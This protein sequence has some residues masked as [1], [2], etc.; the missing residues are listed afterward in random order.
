MRLI[1][2]FDMN[3]NEGAIQGAKIAR[4]I[5]IKSMIPPATAAL[6]ASSLLQASDQRTSLAHAS[7]RARGFMSRTA[8][9]DKRL[10]KIIRVEKKIVVPRIIV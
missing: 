6:L 5:K 8:I 3:K 2:G 10:K 9:S 1:Q 7:L 4:K